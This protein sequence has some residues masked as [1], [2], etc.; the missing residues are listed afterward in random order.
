MTLL[1]KKSATRKKAGISGASSKAVKP[2]APFNWGPLRKMSLVLVAGLLLGGVLEIVSIV[3]SQPVTR[4]AVRGEF[5]HVD[6]EAVIT[7]V[8][9]FLEDGFVMLDLQ[10]IREQLIQQP[11]IFDVALAR[12]WPDEIEIMVEEQ[13]VIARWGDAGFLNHRGELFRPAITNIIEDDLPV[14]DGQDTD[15]ALVVNHFRELSAV[16]AEHHLG[17]K[18]LQLNER[19]TW[20]ASLDSGVEIIIGSGA[21][22]EKMRR[23]LSAYEQGLSTDFGQ[24]ESIDMR[25]NNGFSVAWR[26]DTKSVA[27]VKA[28]LGRQ[29]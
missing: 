5:K 4:I 27:A 1:G 11:W 2:S 19:N 21:V 17:L 29:G 28:T 10:G 24:I 25:Y 3:L 26:A 15:T 8:K 22:M 12:H 14:L 13:T 6:K 9:P 7:K 18:K 16:L 23:L 20:L